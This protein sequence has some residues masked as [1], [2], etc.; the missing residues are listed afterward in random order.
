MTL[1]EVVIYATLLAFLLAGTVNS[2]YVIS[3]ENTVLISDID[4]AYVD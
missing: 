2:L 1:I 4:H 3:A